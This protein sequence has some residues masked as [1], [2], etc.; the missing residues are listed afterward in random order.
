MPGTAVPAELGPGGCARPFPLLR[1][2]FLALSCQAVLTPFSETVLLSFPCR[3]LLR[4]PFCAESSESGSL[5]RAGAARRVSACCCAVAACCCCT[6]SCSASCFCCAARS[7]GAAP[8]CCCCSC[9]SEGCDAAAGCCWSDGCVCSSS[10][11]NPGESAA[12]TTTTH[13]EA[14]TF[15]LLII[16]QPAAAAPSC[17]C[18]QWLMADSYHR[19]SGW[20]GA[21]EHSAPPMHH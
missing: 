4:L 16:Q 1:F 18:W 20:C 11:T 12:P 15:E 5:Q 2:P 17:W 13:D 7:C 6:A 3:V 19:S 8:C 21:L 9:W 10:E 14:L